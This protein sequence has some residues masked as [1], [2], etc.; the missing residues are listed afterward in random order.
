[1]PSW[2]RSLVE[3]R[4]SFYGCHFL[5]INHVMIWIAPTFAEMVS[6]TELEAF[7]LE[8]LRWRPVN[9]FGPSCFFLHTSLKYAHYHPRCTSPGNQRRLL[10]TFTLRDTGVVL[11]VDLQN[12]YCIP[13][14]ATVFGNHW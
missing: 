5:V 8:A 4:V 3:M 13:A 1:M 14:G 7:I 12:G 11:K 10:G 9:P 2:M 6:L